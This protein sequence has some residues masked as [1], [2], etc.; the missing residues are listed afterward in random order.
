[1]FEMPCVAFM[2]SIHPINILVLCLVVL[3]VVGPKRL[4]EVA[5][6][7][8]RMMETFRRAADEFKSQL[9]SMDQ[10]PPPSTPADT[11]TDVDGVKQPPSEADI[12]SQGSPY[13]GNE[14]YAEAL[15]NPDGGSASSQTATAH[16]DVRPPEEEPPR[17]SGTPPQEGNEPSPEPEKPPEP[18]ATP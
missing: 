6:K 18:E 17:P 9:M 11:T 3:I 1:M 10:E 16:E 12:Y 2:G 4:P 14:Q 8:G 7:L 15:N 5:R 13:P